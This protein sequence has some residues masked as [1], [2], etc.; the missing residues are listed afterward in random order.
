MAVIQPGICS[1]FIQIWVNSNALLNSKATGIYLVDNTL[2]DGGSNEGSANLLTVVNTGTY[3]CWTLLNIDP[4]SGMQLRIRSFGDADIFGAGG[5]PQMVNATTWT[6]QAQAEG[7]DRY[8]INFSAFNS[9]S[10]PILT[11]VTPSLKAG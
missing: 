9:C 11:R 1:C 2:H 5:A 3:I 8:A 7:T 4:V 6:G 10:T